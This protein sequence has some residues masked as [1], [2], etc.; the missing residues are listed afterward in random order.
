MKNSK[1]IF[2]LLGWLSTKP[3]SGYELKNLTERYVGEFWYGSFGQ[4]Y[5]L[6]RQMLEEGLVTMREERD[7]GHPPR[8]V[9]TITGAGRAAFERWMQEPPEE[10][11]FRSE[12]LLKLFFG[13]LA[14]PG[15][16]VEQV[17][18]ALDSARAKLTYYERLHA[19]LSEQYAGTPDLPFMLITLDRGMIVNRGYVE[20][21]ERTL[22]TLKGI[23][24]QEVR[25]EP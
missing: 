9:Y 11:L 25:D 21:A 17:R 19:M 6:L 8:K 10:D 22:E 16:L 14:K 4:I 23:H 1:T 18:A 24:P 2:A 5:P 15:A 13:H 3:H 20:W 7:T 12:L